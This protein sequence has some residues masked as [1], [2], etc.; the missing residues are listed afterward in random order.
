MFD[1]TK[2]YSFS[3][4]ALVFNNNRSAPILFLTF[5]IDRL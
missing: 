4:V 2:Q 1:W 3:E 5:H